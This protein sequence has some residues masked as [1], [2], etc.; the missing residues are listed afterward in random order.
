MC[1][2]I[3]PQPDDVTCGPTSL[4]AVYRYHGLDIPLDELIREI[5]YIEEGG[6]SAVLL[7]IDALKRGFQVRLHT[8]NLRVF[9]LT[10]AKLGREDLIAKLENQLL[11]LDDRKLTQIS[12]D[13]IRFLKMGGE[14]VCKEISPALLRGYFSQNTPVLAGLSVTYLYGCMREY[15][16]PDNRAVLDD[17][18]GEPTGHFV[19]LYGIDDEHRVLV[20]DPDSHSDMTPPHYYQI[21]SQHLIHS[22]LIGILTFDAYLIVITPQ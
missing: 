17:L 1:I 3:L 20:A 10:W 4:H 6:T 18:V 22:I 13:Y 7:G 12:H 16:S 2:E 21:E 19:V 9:D 14:I 11:H 8:F 15:T 5:E